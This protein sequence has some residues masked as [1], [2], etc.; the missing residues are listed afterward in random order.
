M[1]GKQDT[2][3]RQSGYRYT[4]THTHKHGVVVCPK[5]NSATR[6]RYPNERK[7][8]YGVL[9]C[10]WQILSSN[11]MFVKRLGIVVLR[12]DGAHHVNSLQNDTTCGLFLFREFHGGHFFPGGECR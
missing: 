1:D 8:T 12:F 2:V 3:P 10:K 7:L 6:H 4:H 9:Y 11:F 5:Y